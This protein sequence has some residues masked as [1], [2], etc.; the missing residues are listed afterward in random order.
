MKRLLF[1][2]IA[3]VL[4]TAFAIAQKG[5]FSI[6]APLG[7]TFKDRVKFDASYADVSDGFQYGAG[8]EYFTGNAQSLELSYQRIGVDFPLYGPLG[9]KL[10]DGSGS[11]NYIL[12]GGNGYFGKSYD[13][14]TQPFFGGGIGIGILEGGGESATKFA[15]NLKTGIKF[16]TGKA[17]SFK[18]NAYLQSVISTFGYDY[19]STW[20]GPV[21][22]PDYATLLQFGLGGAICLDFP[23]KK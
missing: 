8:L 14:K 22:V 12:L 20:Y 19:W 3:M 23:K 7:Y 15:W 1:S 18:L 4:M 10:S 9:T 16:N 2:M 5:T 6:N 17:V 13:A 21:A 11:V